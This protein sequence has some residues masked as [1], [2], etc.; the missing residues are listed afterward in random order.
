MLARTT[1]RCLARGI[2]F[3]LRP[4]LHPARAADLVTGL[5]CRHCP[6]YVFAR[7]DFAM[8]HAASGI[9][10]PGERT[11]MPLREASGDQSACS[12]LARQYGIFGFCAS[13]LPQVATA[14]A[15]LSADKAVADRPSLL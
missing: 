8:M 3:R 14:D 13:G 7:T 9:F 15:A 1:E 6:Q 10:R 4:G 12:L 5:A 2:G 11:L